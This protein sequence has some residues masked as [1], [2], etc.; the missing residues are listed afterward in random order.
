[1]GMCNG[2]VMHVS[3]TPSEC[4]VFVAGTCWRCVV[5][6]TVDSQRVTS[7]CLLASGL[8]FTQ[9]I[10]EW[11]FH[12]T[13]T[14]KNEF[15]CFGVCTLPI[16]DAK[17]STSDSMWLVRAYNGDVHVRG[18]VVSRVSPVRAGSV[19]HFR[20]VQEENAVYMRVNEGS[21]ERALVGLPAVDVRV[22]VTAWS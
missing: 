8:F 18:S 7:L 4:A 5:L 12:L 20:A 16:T 6:H 19:V 22:Y 13:A 21:Y 3:V 14:D 15:T 1:M 17:Y 11:S 2:R 10:T 9:G